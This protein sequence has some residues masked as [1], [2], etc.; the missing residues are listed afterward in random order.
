MNKKHL[1]AFLPLLIISLSAC[2]F[3]MPSG[4]EEKDPPIEVTSISLDESLLFTDLSISKS[5]YVT[6]TPRDGKT[7]YT[8]SNTNNDVVSIEGLAKECVVTS[9]NYGTSTITVTTSNGLSKS[10]EVTVRDDSEPIIEVTD[11]SLISDYTFESFAEPK[12]IGVTITPSDGVT[13][14]T[15]SN[16]NDSVI[17]ISPNNKLCSITP[18]NNGTSTVTV[19]TGNLLT[20]SCVVTVDVVEDEPSGVQEVNIVAFND[21]HGAIDEKSSQMGLAKVGTYLKRKGA[22]ENTLTLS[23]GDDWQ[24]SIY[25]NYNRGRL[26]NDVYASAKLSARTIG[27]HDF[28]WGV[29]ALVANTSASY[30]GYRTPVLAA[31]VYDYNFQTKTV[32]TTQQSNIGQKT[33]TYRLNNG[34]K[35]GIV[36]VIGQDQITSITSSY[37]TN[38]HFINHIDVIKQE[39]TNLRNNGCHIVIASVHTGSEEVMSQSLGNYVDLVLCGH[40]HSEESYTEGDLYYYQFGCYGK[41]LGNI[42]LTYDCNSNKVTNTTCT[43]ITSSNIDNY[44]SSTDSEIASI[45][46]SYNEACSSEANQVVAKTVNGYYFAKNEHLPNLV[47]KAIYDQAVSEGHNDVVMTMVNVARAY[48]NKETWTYADIYEAFPFDNTVY[49]YDALGSEIKKELDYNYVYMSSSF[50]REIKLNQR[51]RI[52][53]LDYLL[54]HTNSNRYYDYFSTFTGVTV[55]E[56][57]SNYRL[58]LKSWLT[59]NGYSSGTKILSSDDYSSSSTDFNKSAIQYS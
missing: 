14:Y 48:I 29:D 25:S 30:N 54:F 6:P 26:V 56:L 32:G 13:T 5:I 42:K 24:G 53:V 37:T 18:L 17:S 22:E 34:L 4:G 16:S 43:S 21:F 31:N 44:I 27:N 49:I 58:I 28:D 20:A 50:N 35:V 19:T 12:T 55:D 11:I 3:T 38:I 23:Q 41:T 39:A 52:A 7:T 15:W 2:T 9:L 46:A 1:L 36:G 51:Y 59:N 47:C 33:V 45:I 8:W 40:T 10:C 57:N